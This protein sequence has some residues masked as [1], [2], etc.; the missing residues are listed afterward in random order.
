MIDKDAEEA[1]LVEKAAVGRTAKREENEEWA[2]KAQDK[3]AGDPS[4][5]PPP[6]KGVD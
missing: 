4:A 3:D 6:E 1:A 5:E 2:R